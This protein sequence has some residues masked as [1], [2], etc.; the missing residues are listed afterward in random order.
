MSETANCAAESTGMWPGRAWANNIRLRARNGTEDVCLVALCSACDF[1]KVLVIASPSSRCFS[2]VFA[3]YLTSVIDCKLNHHA[4]T[5]PVLVCSPVP[6]MSAPCPDIGMD[7]QSLELHVGQAK[8][9]GADGCPSFKQASFHYAS[10]YCTT[11][12][13]H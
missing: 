8:P 13:P 12:T 2:L 6:L 1:S 5:E 11:A 4:M 10:V 3:C 7:W 9:D